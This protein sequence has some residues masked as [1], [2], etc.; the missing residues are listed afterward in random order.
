MFNV[1]PCVMP[2]RLFR[3][4]SLAS[5][6]VVIGCVHT[7]PEPAAVWEP[8]RTY[9]ITASDLQKPDFFVVDV[10]TIRLQ[11]LWPMADDWKADCLDPAFLAYSKS[12]GI[13]GYVRERTSHATDEHTTLVNVLASD[14]QYGLVP[15]T[16]EWT[17][18]D[19]HEVLSYRIRADGVP[20][21]V[22]RGVRLLPNGRTFELHVLW[23]LP[24]VDPTAEAETFA[25]LRWMVAHMKWLPPDPGPHATK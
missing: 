4:A 11:T 23:A 7:P 19:G 24:A 12:Q 1:L 9:T 18:I 5:T 16:V 17:T 8:C 14:E 6:A 21:V 13:I 3:W 10:P 2:V 22:A 20:S 25:K 15:E